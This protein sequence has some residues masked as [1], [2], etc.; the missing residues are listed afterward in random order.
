MN[1]ADKSGAESDDRRLGDTVKIA[2]DYQYEALNNGPG[3]QRAW[4][5]EKLILLNSWP[6]A[7]KGDKGLDVGF[8]SGVSSAHLADM[9]CQMWG[10]DSNPDAVAFAQETFKSKNCKFTLGQGDDF[11]LG[12]TFDFVISL[13]VIEHLYENQIQA[14]L[15]SMFKHLRPGGHLLLSTPNYRG[16]WPIIEKTC[17]RFASLP[18]MDG[19]QHVTHFHRSNLKDTVKRAGFTEIK[20]STFCTVSPV[21]GSIVPKSQSAL[22]K[23]EKSLHLPFGNLLTCTA[24]K[25]Q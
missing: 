24:T 19:D 3:F 23:L 8:G 12:E 21:I 15:G 2:G 7:R 11:D 5:R 16:T 18:Q 22:A 14:L 25:P 20:I 4:H 1:D 6:H 9:G 17:D 10:V 13:E